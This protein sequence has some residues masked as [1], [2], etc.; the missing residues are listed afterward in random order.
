[1]I[2]GGSF[3]K[4]TKLEKIVSDRHY[5]LKEL[6]PP[7]GLS[8][9]DSLTHVGFKSGQLALFQW[10][11]ETNF[12]PF[13][14]KS[15]RKWKYVQ[16]PQEADSVALPFYSHRVKGKKQVI[17]HQYERVY[18]LRHGVVIAVFCFEEGRFVQGADIYKSGVLPQLSSN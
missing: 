7:G 15:G 13:F 11:G 17:E 10:L 9:K 5:P 16:L 2:R 6:A 12:I 1:M 3:K 14:A 18:F 4:L 8:E